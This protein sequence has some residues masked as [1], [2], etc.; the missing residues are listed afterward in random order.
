MPKNLPK[1]KIEKLWEKLHGFAQAD[2]MEWERL[3]ENP[4]LIK[5]VQNLRARFDLPVSSFYDYHAWVGVFEPTLVKNKNGR[6]VFGEK[7][8]RLQKFNQEKDKL[9]AEFKI[10]DKFLGNFHNWICMGNNCMLG[11]TMFVCPPQPQ[12]LRNNKKKKDYRP[13]WEW[14][15]RHPYFSRKQIAE[16]LNIHVVTLKRRLEEIDK[17]TEDQ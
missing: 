1:N 4:E 3:I 15:K 16:M 9:A 5:G 7:L 6:I 13:I 10:P 2:K 8:Q 12:P 17:A 11:F 14:E